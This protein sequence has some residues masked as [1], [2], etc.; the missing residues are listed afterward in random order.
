MSDFEDFS[1]CLNSPNGGVRG[2]S[3]GMRR[4]LL[5]ATDGFRRKGASVSLIRVPQRS[6]QGVQRLIRLGFPA[7]TGHK[8]TC[9]PG[10]SATG[11]EAACHL[12]SD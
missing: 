6:E 11:T 9:E 7:P 5:V 3:R 12:L 8:V 4:V 1:V 2:R 10:D